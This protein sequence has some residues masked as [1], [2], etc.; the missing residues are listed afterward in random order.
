MGPVGND[1]LYTTVLLYEQRIITV[2]TA[3]AQLK[4]HTLLYQ[5]SFHSERALETLKFKK[6]KV[7]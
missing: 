1:F 6:I 3:I 5:L 7:L 2:D 4:P